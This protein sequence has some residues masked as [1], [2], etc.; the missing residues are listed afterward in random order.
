M[1]LL[2][3]IMASINTHAISAY[4]FSSGTPVSSN[5]KIDRYDMTNILLK[6][7]LNPIT[8]THISKC[9]SVY[10]VQ[11]NMHSLKTL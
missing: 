11:T 2:G 5:N 10:V 4:L 9:V 1:T 3:T 7:V 6:V 8:L